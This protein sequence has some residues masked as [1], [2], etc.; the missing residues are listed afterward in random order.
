MTALPPVEAAPASRAAV[1][2]RDVTLP[3]TMIRTAA[4]ALLSLWTAAATATASAQE[5]SALSDERILRPSDG[6]RIES[7]RVRYSHFDQAGHGY[8]SQAGPPFGPGSEAVTVEQPQV[9]VVAKQGRRVTHRLW[10]PLDVITAASPDA[11][12]GWPPPDAVSEASR[13]NVAVNLDL[14]STY[15]V[16]HATDFSLR[17][18]LHAEE[19][20]RSWNLGAGFSRAFADDNAV[21]SASLNQVFD[22]FD[23]FTIHGVRLGLVARSST[24]GNLGLTQLL[25][26]TTVAHLNYGVTVQVGE[27]GNTWNSVPIIDGVP[28]EEILPRLRHRHAFVG[29]LA[30]ALP[31]QAAVKGFYRFYVDN[32][33]LTGHTF[34]LELLQR[35]TA[36]AYVRLNYRVHQQNG[37]SFFLTLAPQEPRRRTADSDL[38]PFVAQTFGGKLAI[39]LGFVRRLRQLHFDIGYE[40]YLR[41]NDLRATIYSCA[42]GLLF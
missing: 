29:R 3:I 2:G 27:L 37:V 34:E 25:S 19:Q 22:W 40:R 36:W 38:A 35:L 23:R 24:N 21:I 26:P 10:I 28:A 8:Q 41:S 14:T 42:L 32:W 5:A 7:V 39:D 11:I 17:F 30:Q 16:D 9:E 15:Q 18:G 4:T 1:F 12:D 33:G 20:F 31:W 6:Y 13:F